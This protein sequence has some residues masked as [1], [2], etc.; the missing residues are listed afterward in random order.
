M[1]ASSGTPPLLVPYT[2]NIKNFDRKT[3]KWQSYNKYPCEISDFVRKFENQ[4]KK[5]LDRKTKKITRLYRFMKFL[6]FLEKLK[7][8]KKKIWTEKQKKIAIKVL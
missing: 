3:E 6:I 1:L 8:K 7:I 4:E 2:Y 5:N